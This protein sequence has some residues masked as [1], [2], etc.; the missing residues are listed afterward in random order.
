M[1]IQFGHIIRI[2]LAQF[3]FFI[4]FAS[5]IC[6][7]KFTFISMSFC[8]KWAWSPPANATPSDFP[9]PKSWVLDLSFEVSFASLLAM[10]L[11]ECWKR[12]EIFFWNYIFFCN[13]LKI[14]SFWKKKIPAFFN[15]LKEPFLVQKQ[16]ILQKTG[17]ILSFLQLESLRVWH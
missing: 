5:W 15:I 2:K 16:T 9:S 1:C 14:I 11:S 4:F 7:V 17:L 8:S 13:F 3:L 6:S 10:V 12:L